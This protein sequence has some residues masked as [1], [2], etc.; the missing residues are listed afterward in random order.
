MAEEYVVRLPRG[1]VV[2]LF[3]ALSGLYCARGLAILLGI[4]EASDD[5]MQRWSQA[6][7]D[8][9]GNFGWRDEP[10]AVADK[11]NE[12]MHAL[13]DRRQDRHRASGTTRPFR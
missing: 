2:D 8:G 4:E 9:A 3:P 6:L 10:F 5:E 12:E 1:E 7:I 13:F 11:A